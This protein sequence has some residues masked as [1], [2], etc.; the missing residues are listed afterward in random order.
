MIFREKLS[1]FFRRHR[2]NIKGFFMTHKKFKILKNY[3]TSR[4]WQDFSG[5]NFLNFSVGIGGTSKLI[6]LRFVKENFSFIAWPNPFK[7]RLPLVEL[8]DK[9]LGEDQRQ[10][11]GRS[12][13]SKKFPI[14]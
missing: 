4:N 1:H 14:G 8:L 2:R 12:Y 9:N 7:K 3:E 11:K 10:F 6:Y 5:K 13:D